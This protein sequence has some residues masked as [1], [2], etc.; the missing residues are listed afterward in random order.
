MIVRSLTCSRQIRLIC[1]TQW[2]HWTLM[3]LSVAP[4]YQSEE[5]LRNSADSWHWT[6]GS[7]WC[8]FG[9]FCGQI[10]LLLGHIFKRDR[11]FPNRSWVE[12]LM[13]TSSFCLNRQCVPSSSALILCQWLLIFSAPW[14][15]CTTVEVTK[16]SLKVNSHH[17]GM[18]LWWKLECQQA[19]QANSGVIVT[20]TKR[21]QIYNQELKKKKGTETENLENVASSSH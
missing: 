11:L 20:F 4:F 12:L 3:F 9:A 1:R 8:P 5:E 14:K 16:F 21:L 15:D 10:W 6:H 2:A 7:M 13:S 19:E 18:P 17:G